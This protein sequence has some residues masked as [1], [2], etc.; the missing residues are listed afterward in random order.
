VCVIAKGEDYGAVCMGIIDKFQCMPVDKHV[1]VIGSLNQLSSRDVSI[2]I[3][4]I[5]L[6]WLLATTFSCCFPI[7]PFA[8]LLFVSLTDFRLGRRAQKM[9]FSRQSR[10]YAYGCGCEYVHSHKT[11]DTHTR[12]GTAYF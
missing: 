9:S 12:T 6:L 8:L 2:V 4:F 5:A 7:S 11:P 10:R 3:T 1:V